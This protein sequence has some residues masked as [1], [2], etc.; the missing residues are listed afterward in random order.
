MCIQQSRLGLVLEK[1]GKNS[2]SLEKSESVVAGCGSGHRR[3]SARP[4]G[5]GQARQHHAVG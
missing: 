4:V 1:V 2:E 3:V 5:L